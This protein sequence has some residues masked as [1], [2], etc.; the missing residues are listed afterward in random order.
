[1]VWGSQRWGQ[2]ESRRV[3]KGCF[4]ASS[5]RRRVAI[6]GSGPPAEIRWRLGADEHEQVLG[7]LAMAAA[8][9]RPSSVWIGMAHAGEGQ[10]GRARVAAGAQVTRGEGGSR[11]WSG[12]VQH[13]GGRGSCT[14]PAAEGAEQ[15]RA[16]QR[17]K[18]GGV[19]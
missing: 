5:W 4:T 13:S 6:A 2:L 9:C 19:V 18:K 8:R 3:G 14:A 12:S 10:Q 1:V 16:C 11:R 15:S 17:K 7:K